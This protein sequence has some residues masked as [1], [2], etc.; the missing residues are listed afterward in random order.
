MYAYLFR[1]GVMVAKKDFFAPKHHLISQVGNRE[2]IQLMKSLVSRKYVK[3]AFNTANDIYD[4][5]Y[6]NSRELYASNAYQNKYMH[7]IVT[8]ETEKLSDNLKLFLIG[9]GAGLVL[10]LVMWVA[11]AFI[12]E[13]KNVKKA[14]EMKEAE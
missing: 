1:E 7:T 3:E 2:L 12:I 10:G 9:A 4:L 11:D 14:N 5:V 6:N 8:S 13:F